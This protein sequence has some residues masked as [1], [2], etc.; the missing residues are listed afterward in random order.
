MTPPAA[1]AV[2][3]P[4]WRRRERARA[5]VR[6]RPPRVSGWALPPGRDGN[7]AGSSRSTSSSRDDRHACRWLHAC[8][9]GMA[10]LC[11]LPRS[12]APSAAVAGA[13]ARASVHAA[14]QITPCV[15]QTCP[16][17]RPCAVFSCLRGERPSLA[18][19][20]P[21]HAPR[22]LRRRSARASAQ[23]PPPPSSSPPPLL[24]LPATSRFPAFPDSD[25]HNV[26]RRP[27]NPTQHSQQQPNSLPDAA[28]AFAPPAGARAKCRLS[29]RRSDAS[30]RPMAPSAGRRYCRLRH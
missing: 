26:T 7:G 10:R 29:P 2:A 13:H 22:P 14:Y 12:L 1:A 19:Q 28:A 27:S 3:A 11:S 17:P 8:P 15:A 5:W 6:G 16:P 30:L 9:A 23:P 4:P 21:L 25:P 20:R 18:N 24:L